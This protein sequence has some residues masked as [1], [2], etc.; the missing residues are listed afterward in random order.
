[1]LRGASRAPMPGLAD[2]PLPLLLLVGVLS[3]VTF[4]LCLLDKGRARAGAR[5]VPERTLLV[6]ALLG[7]SP[8]LVMGMLV[9]RHKTRK[10]AFLLPLALVLALQLAALWFVYLGPR[11]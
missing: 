2:L 10:A 7:G 8:G 3:V 6:L 1:M 5:R 11:R 4:L 9:A